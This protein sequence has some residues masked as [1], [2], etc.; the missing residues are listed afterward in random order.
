MSWSY[1]MFNC[2]WGVFVQSRAWVS[3]IWTWRVCEYLI[4]LRPVHAVILP[5]LSISHPRYVASHFWHIFRK[6]RSFIQT[7][8][9]SELTHG[10]ALRHA[11]ISEVHSP[12]TG[13]LISL[14]LCN[15]RLPEAIWKVAIKLASHFSYRSHRMKWIAM[16][17][18][19]SHRTVSQELWTIH[20]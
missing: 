14:F 16:S 17:D 4:R 6:A 2:L 15:S 8:T 12:P 7:R 3:R 9:R 10:R 13:G 19:R 5:Q 11:T 20:G 1:L 18:Q